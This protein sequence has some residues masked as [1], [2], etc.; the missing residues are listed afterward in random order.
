MKL[1][2]DKGRL[3]GRINLLDLAVII[4]VLAVL[5]V[6]VAAWVA[7]RQK[8][9]TITGLNPA[10]IT[11]GKPV[12]I[13]LSLQNER[14]IESIRLHLISGQPGA[15]TTTLSGKVSPS[16]RDHADFTIPADLMSGNYNLQIEA[17]LRDVF[18]RKSLQTAM[19]GKIQLV[20]ADTVVVAVEEAAFNPKCLWKLELNTVLLSGGETS[21]E[22][23]T[24]LS[25]ETGDGMSL[26]L[27]GFEPDPPADVIDK[28]SAEN[29]EKALALAGLEVTASYEHLEPLLAG[30]ES[31]M[32]LTCNDSPLEAV[33]EGALFAELDMLFYLEE[34]DQAG[35][36]I[37][38]AA[39]V[40]TDGR[41]TAIVLENFGQVS[42]PWVSAAAM[43]PV[44]NNSPSFSVA[45]V[46]LACRPDN[47][48]LYFGS[49]HLEPNRLLTL[50][51]GDTRIT[52]GILSGTATSITTTIRT[53]LDNVPVHL[54]PLLR[55]GVKVTNH[56]GNLNSGVIGRVLDVDPLALLPTNPG[57]NQGSVGRDFRRVL[58]DLE[59]ECT[60]RNGA[61]FFQGQQIDYGRAFNLALLGHPFSAISYYGSSLPPR[62]KLAD[63][64][65]QV[66]FTNVP[67]SIVPWIRAGEQEYLPGKPSSWKI[68]RVMSNEP[69]KMLNSSADGRQAHLANHPTNRDIR[70][71]VSIQLVKKGDDSFYNGNQLKIGSGIT[72]NAR[73]WSFAASMAAF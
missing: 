7:L 31:A 33:A 30:L 47:G 53:L 43:P 50:R 9:L 56:K 14:Y 17:Q 59:L 54:V 70:C 51:S 18:Y 62:G 4:G 57:Y 73:R 28:L 39:L 20:V 72:F 61:L 71:L 10:R 68:E 66:V 1:I 5:Y 16:V 13:T 49:T 60:S 41:D 29:K 12:N 32:A 27:T 3:F 46:R 24:G 69:G 42:N 25:L 67:P 64:K 21:P 35:L 26:T 23:K 52:G 44:G 6:G 48:G 34:D 58:L 65:I 37:K 11:S 45:R 22:L 55:S 2:D 63:V 19:G 8:P 40:T 36:L 38:D 15:E